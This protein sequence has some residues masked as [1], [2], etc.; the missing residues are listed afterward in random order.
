MFEPSMGSGADGML[1]E[2][3]CLDGSMGWKR[4]GRRKSVMRERERERSRTVSSHSVFRSESIEK[5]RALLQFQRNSF[6]RGW[7]S[8]ELDR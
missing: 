3:E 4:V 8:G 6:A 1:E 5:K 7:S 2:N